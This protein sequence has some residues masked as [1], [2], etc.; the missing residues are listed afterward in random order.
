MGNTQSNQ[1]GYVDIV[2]YEGLYKINILGDIWSC[3]KK[4]LLKNYVSCRG[5]KQIGLCKDGKGKTYYIHRLIALHFIPNPDY[6]PC[7]DHINRVKADNRIENLR[8]IS[9]S[10]NSINSDRIDNRKGSIEVLRY[11]SKK[12][13]KIII[14]FRFRYTLRGEYSTNRYKHSKSFKTMEEAEAFREQVYC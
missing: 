11:T 4:K 1:S 10:D 13:G 6:L 2:G 5:Y 9:K 3:N 8:W 14:T 12:T 7:I